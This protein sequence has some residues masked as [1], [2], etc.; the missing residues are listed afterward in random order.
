MTVNHARL[1][2]IRKMTVTT[3]S[4]E[5]LRELIQHLAEDLD[6]RGAF[7]SSLVFNG[8]GYSNPLALNEYCRTATQVQLE[9]VLRE[10]NQAESRALDRENRDR[11]WAEEEERRNRPMSERELAEI[12][13]SQE[14]ARLAHEYRTSTEGRLEAIEAILERIAA[15]LEK[16]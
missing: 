10:I 3:H 7:P 15:G 4:P 2:R 13:E 9:T 12:A 6:E 5:S 8:Q 11:R 14:R 16:R 1:E